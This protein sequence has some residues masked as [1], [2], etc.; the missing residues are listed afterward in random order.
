[1]WQPTA[2]DEL[3]LPQVGAGQMEDKVMI[4]KK[5]KKTLADRVLDML[6][7]FNEAQRTDRYGKRRIQEPPS[8]TQKKPSWIDRKNNNNINKDFIETSLNVF[9]IIQLIFKYLFGDNLN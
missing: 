8:M 2:M 3:Y 5:K 9:N 7:W 4:F 1:M 6:D